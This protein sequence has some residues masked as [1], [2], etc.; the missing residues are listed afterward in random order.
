MKSLFLAL[1]PTQW[2]KNLIVYTAV[3]FNGLLFDQRLFL[4]VFY[5][6]FVFCLISSASYLINDV[7]DFAFDKKHPAKKYRPIASGKVSKTTALISA[8]ILAIGGFLLA[9]YLSPPFFAVALLFF[10]VHVLYTFFLKGLA[11][12]DILMIALSFSLRAFAGEIL[13]GLH[14]PIWLV[15]AIVFLSLFVASAK[16]HS[17]LLRVG[18]IARPSLFSYKER[19]LDFYATTF[20]T[21]TL[22]SYALFVFFQEP[23]RLNLATAQL[24]AFVSPVA[25]ERKWLILTFPFVLLGIM[26][27][28][29]IVYE[30]RG[31]QAPE[32]LVTQDL[33]LI[34]TILGWGIMVVSIIYLV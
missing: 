29:Q 14:V 4:Q 16:R 33:P 31:A 15:L 34:G 6:F 26:R 24:L 28:G 17:E 5:G 8:A 23:P 1:R 13:T 21:A 12:I 18:S 20:A 9:Y 10:V 32:K 2:L 22:I 30:K 19:L 7:K 25:L 3:T 11:V 27:Y